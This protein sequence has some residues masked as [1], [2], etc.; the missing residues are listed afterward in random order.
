MDGRTSGANGQPSWLGDGW[1]YTPGYI[2]RSY[3]SCQDDGQSIQD[4]C[5]Y[6][7]WNATI[8]WGGTSSPLV[9]DTVGGTGWHAAD[10]SGLRVEQLYG[11]TNYTADGQYWRVTTMDGVQYY[12]GVGKRYASDPNNTLSTAV[13]PVFGDDAGDD[14]YQGALAA[15]WC[16]LGYRWHLDYV[17]DPRGNSMTYF[18][19]KY[20]GAYGLNN[21][22]V[23]APYDVTVTLDRIEY[24][25]RAGSEGASSAPMKVQF[26]ASN[27][28][29]PSAANCA[30]WPDV[31]WDIYCS[32]AWASCG[33]RTPTFWTPSKLDTITTKVWNA[34]SSTY[35]DVDRWD[36][37]YTFPS[38]DG[39]NSVLWLNNIQHTGLAGGSLAEPPM[40]FVGTALKNRVYGTEPM[41][42]FRLSGID[43]GT[44]G[45]KVINYEGSGCMQ[46]LLSTFN[47]RYNP[48]RCYPSWNGTG[49]DWYEK[50]TFS[51]IRD[52]D[53]LGV[54]PERWTFYGYSNDGGG[55]NQLWAYDTNEIA[56]AA[57]R[58]WSRYVGYSTVTTKQGPDDAHSTATKTLYYRGL[59]DDGFEYDGATYA[60]QLT[61]SQ[62]VTSPDH[63]ALAGKVR[64]QTTLDGTTALSSTITDY[65]VTQTAKRVTAIPSGTITAYRV[66][67]AAT[68]GRTYLAGSSSWRWN[69]TE[70]SYN[71]DGLLTITRDLGE[72]GT[73]TG[74]TPTTDDVCTI[75]TYTTPDTAKWF[76]SYVARSVTTNCAASP[77]GADYLAGSQMF[78]DNLA[79]G[80][81]PTK[82]L[83]TR[84]ES[85]ATVAGTTLTWQQE[86]RAGYDPTTGRPVDSWDAA[87]NNTHIA[88]TPATGGPVTSVTTT[89][90]LGQSGTVNRDPVRGVPS[91]IVDANGKITTVQYDPLGRLLKVWQPGRATNLTASIEYTYTVGTAT[92]PSVITTKRLGPKGNQI[93]SYEIYDGLLQLRQTQQ[94]AA[95]ANGGRRVIDTAYDGRGLA[96]KTSTFWNTSAPSGTVASFADTDVANQVTTS[97]DRLNRPTATAQV[98]KGTVLWQ[99]TAGYDGDRTW[100]VPPAGGT[101]TMALQDVSGKTTE[102]RQYLTG[103]PPGGTS[104]HATTYAYDRLD[105]LT[106][107][108][109]QSGNTWTSVYNL[110]GQVTSTTDPDKGTTSI[111]YDLAGRPTTVTDARTG[112]VSTT[113]D[114]DELG[115]PRALYDG[116][117]TT[118]FKRVKWTYDT[119]AI[120]QLTSSTRYVGTDE[121]TSTVTGYDD[122]YRP[123]GVTTVIPSSLNMPW[124]PSGSYTTSMTYNVDGSAKT[125]TY[126]AAGNLPV[127]TLTSTYDDN[128]YALTLSGLQTYIA[129]TTYY[130]FGAQSQ[131]ILGSG[132]KRV[133]QTADIDQ[134]TGRLTSSKTET[135]NAASPN[136]WTERLTEG[137]GYD[138]AGNVKNI[139]ETLG[140]STVSNQ[141]F[142]YDA[143]G[144]LT[145]AWTT[146]VAACQASPSAGVVGG[147]DAYWTSYQYATGLSTYNSGN[148]TKEIRHAIG[149]G[150]DTTRSYTYPATGKKHT[151]TNVV[152]TGG[153]T[154]T[155]SYTYDNAGNMLTRNIAGKPGQTLT[156]D[157][158]GHLATVSDS[159]G[160][161]SY[162]YDAS[163][164]RLVAK[165]PAGATV[166]LAGYELRK[167]GGTVT[168]TRYYGVASRTP[169]GLT[170][171]AADHHGTGQLAIDA[172]T[173]A[174]TRRKTDAFGNPRGVDPS[175]PNPRGFVGGTRDSTGLT[176]LGA[177]E[178][179]PGTGRFISD[180]S[181]TDVTSPLQLNGYS[182]ANNTPVTLSDPTGLEPRPW[183]NPNYDPNTCAGGKGGY[184]CH[185]RGVNNDQDSGT[186][187]SKPGQGG[188][189]KT[190]EQLAAEAAAEAAKQRLIAVA[191]ELGQI[192]LDELGITA[193]WD[194]FTKGDIGGCVET[195]LTVATSFFGGLLGK[196]VA[197][198]G[199]RVRAGLKVADRIRKLLGDLIDGVQTWLKE[200]KLARLFAKSC[201]TAG[202]SF[203][204]G[205][206]VLLA[207]G[208]SKPIQT[209]AVGDWVIATDPVTGHTAPRE[210]TYLHVNTD[211]QFT[212][213]TVAADGQPAAVIHTTQEHPFYSVTDHTWTF[214]GDVSPGEQ[215]YTADGTT[216]RVLD[217]TNFTSTATMYNLTVDTTHTYYVLA[218]NTPVL[219]HNDNG[220]IYVTGPGGER[221]P[222][223]T[224]D[225]VPGS[226]LD[227]GYGRSY[228]VPEGTE[229][230]HKNVKTVRVMSPS[231]QNPDGYVV[232][233]NAA[234]QTMNPVTGKTTVGKADPYAHISASTLSTSPC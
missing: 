177:R 192:A 33:Q 184:E 95:V 22:A 90:P 188:Q 16:N 187:G 149:G 104:F 204:A 110:L 178:Y 158:E 49:Y 113:L 125:L 62:S 227:W 154:G 65:T 84:T 74:N 4:L 67:T 118:G 152:A 1:D 7:R 52:I 205:T 111:K 212:D 142:G 137:Y 11:A 61:D 167:V 131:Q 222:V 166:Y 3:A 224:I 194:C 38:Y 217:R 122:G 91:T 93:A 223:A 144:E 226:P 50:Y 73:A 9:Q 126:P 197:K 143:L 96:V 94:P 229:G 26:G 160:V 27:R 2:E 29:T 169:S 134:A 37:T 210:I 47:W 173:Q 105:R 211:E 25:T 21:G 77:S 87:N 72:T 79:Y 133:R 147:P 228:D 186:A 14:C 53:L 190:K 12:F 129:E 214:A 232:Y 230:L 146:T 28:C 140:G 182:Y 130:S 85:L 24:G 13:V 150:T 66:T 97:F 89:A 17:V 112:G 208:T 155:D 215:L 102:L 81:A 19:S 202:N 123:S 78:Y 234:G 114:Y 183:H 36:M 8:M 153:S 59:K 86:S 55:T 117:G 92:T 225:S 128:G 45:Q 99:T 200:S 231:P 88:Y 108:A 189:P 39:V 103:S 15:S 60:V 139:A 44:G 63:R 170:W 46:A 76:K 168:G 191:K 199:W 179:E 57:H 109:D 172:V 42:R 34:A 157:S 185:P 176:H 121:F 216:V 145:E 40:T 82:G 101:A 141:C 35:R 75:L 116:V 207:G 171:V 80:A 209:L 124:L 119:I 156:W 107:T 195:A 196:L 148:R 43:T 115:R 18:Y 5:Y 206:L 120:G 198:Y 10:D 98:S 56:P 165:D 135:E 58:N 219:V 162:V 159:A 221:L 48:Y 30:A 70:Y 32:P 138:L 201:R 174:V 100:T 68:K 71:G 127:E 69:R 164:A 20:T 136:T 83:V 180:D 193:A 132:S 64:E 31:P 106:S 233:R 203:A 54:S 175:W 220:W 6:S 213:L 163:G 181:V 41:W 151:L 161:S 23:V 51:W 218:G